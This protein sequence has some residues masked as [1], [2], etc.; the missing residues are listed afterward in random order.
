MQI[1]PLNLKIGISWAF[2]LNQW[3]WKIGISLR[4]SVLDNPIIPIRSMCDIESQAKSE[5]MEKAHPS[6][7]AQ[8]VIFHTWFVSWNANNA[9]ILK[10]HSFS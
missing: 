6:S 4:E 3:K 8:G 1:F 2:W 7:N 9:K 5:N 10:R